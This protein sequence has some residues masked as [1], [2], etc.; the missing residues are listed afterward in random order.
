MADD[1]VS[2]LLEQNEMLQVQLRHKDEAIEALAR[3]NEALKAANQNL[4]KRVAQLEA[5]GGIPD[6]A[7]NARLRSDAE[8]LENDQILPWR[9]VSQPQPPPQPQGEKPAAVDPSEEEKKELPA[10]PQVEVRYG[11]GGEFADVTIL[12]YEVQDAWEEAHIVGEFNSWEP[13]EMVW[14]EDYECFEATARMKAGYKHRFQFR[15]NGEMMVD[16]KLQSSKNAIGKLTNFVFV[17]K[18]A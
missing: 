2:T 10:R 15:V 7:M 14:S 17:P 18:Q 6:T 3:E 11:P 8:K 5:S 1:I 4:I 9:P 13:Q 12:F 16:S